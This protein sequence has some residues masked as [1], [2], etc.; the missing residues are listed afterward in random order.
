MATNWYLRGEGQQVIGPLNSAQLKRLADTR[1]L[2]R[3]SQVARDPAGPWSPASAVQGLFAA[4]PAPPPAATPPPLPEG[5]RHVNQL[6]DAA[7]NPQ[8]AAP[9]NPAMRVL[10]TAGGALLAALTHLVMLPRLAL[11]R[12]LHA[13][14]HR[15]LDRARLALGEAL[16]HR[17]AG[18]PQLLAEV[19]ELDARM[20]GADPATKEG[21]AL[22]AQWNEQMRQLAAAAPAHDAAPEELAAVDRASWRYDRQAARV[23][24]CKAAL[25]PRRS[26]QWARL[27][28]GYAGL[29]SI[30]LVAIFLLRS[31][32]A[33]GELMVTPL[34]GTTTAPLPSPDPL[35]TPQPV[36]QPVPQ[37]L[38][39]PTPQPGPEPAPE[40]SPP[41]PDHTIDHTVEL[42]LVPGISELDYY[43]REE[44]AIQ[45]RPLETIVRELQSAQRTV[46]EAED[47]HQLESTANRTMRIVLYEWKNVGTLKLPAR[48]DSEP[49]GK[50]LRPVLLERYKVWTERVKHDRRKFDQAVLA[51]TLRLDATE[52]VRQ[53]AQSIG[54]TFDPAEEQAFA[55]AAHAHAEQVAAEQA[56]ENERQTA[57]ARVALL[58][59]DKM[60]DLL[61]PTHAQVWTL[62]ERVKGMTHAAL[63]TSSGEPGGKG[64]GAEATIAALRA[65]F[66]GQF[67]GGSELRTAAEEFA[68]VL[69][70]RDL[71]YFQF[72]N[73]DW[74][75]KEVMGFGL[76]EL[77]VDT[78]DELAWLRIPDAS[79]P[80]FESWA[81]ALRDS[82]VLEQY[83][84]G[85]TMAQAFKASLEKHHELYVEYVRIRNHEEFLA[86]HEPL[87]SPAPLIYFT[88]LVLHLPTEAG[89]AEARSTAAALAQ[90]EALAAMVGNEAFNKA[91][92]AAR[93]AP[94][95]PET[96]WYLRTTVPLEALPG[97]VGADS[98]LM[99]HL[100]DQIAK[101]SDRGY[102]V[103]LLCPAQYTSHTA[104][105]STKKLF[106]Q[107]MKSRGLEEMIRIAAK[108]RAAPVSFGKV[109]DAN[110]HWQDE[111]T[112]H[113]WF[114]YLLDD[115]S[116][117]FE[118]AIPPTL[119][120]TDLAKLR[121]HESQGVFVE[122]VIERI[123]IDNP[124]GDYLEGLAL[125]FQGVPIEQFYAS[126][127]YGIIMKDGRWGLTG[128]ALVGKR[129]RISGIVSTGEGT[130]GKM[131]VQLNQPE[132]IQV[133]E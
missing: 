52:E 35:P 83:P 77:I 112:P 17:Q 94:I 51:A 121:A 100:L 119:Q 32:Q 54:Y 18:P 120:A 125:V 114:C 59:W 50:Q 2:D 98:S 116:R 104:W 93:Q 64:Q 109:D 69:I 20:V 45:F 24:E 26:G 91:V 81:K 39:D 3:S 82:C 108:I 48:L 118:I 23:A 89:R 87:R 90:A 103:M 92:A 5:G 105:T 85:T 8:P 76:Q 97:Q 110:T 60:A 71:T 73:A 115:P 63:L 84:Q 68:N 132:Q 19:A 42:Y 6:P 86:A 53:M 28:A 13:Y 79:K 95:D 131:W 15:R 122:G 27:G 72:T 117:K 124:T 67:P 96:P 37:P 111:K 33:G 25:V 36:P 7:V 127:P 41:Q 49:G 9:A 56:K 75:G 107:Y 88:G 130:F 58:A 102:V 129:V 46:A 12:A 66:W 99:E 29:A 44:I 101:G 31:P 38:P 123:A 78:A 106:D 57:Q 65:R 113:E 11:S 47:A 10:A 21:K 43:V 30:A 34:D 40:P 55:A 70:I 80:A 4:E 1:Q 62:Y 61:V 126:C 128:Q 14:S 16:Y 133:L 74:I 22:Q